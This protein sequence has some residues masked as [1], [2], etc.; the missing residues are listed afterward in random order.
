MESNRVRTRSNSTD[1]NGAEC[2]DILYSALP[3]FLF[4]VLGCVC[5]V[6]FVVDEVEHWEGLEFE[7]RPSGVA[8][9]S[10]LNPF[11]LIRLAVQRQTFLSSSPK[12]SQVH[13]S[14]TFVLRPPPESETRPLV[15]E[16]KSANKT[17]NS[18]NTQWNLHVCF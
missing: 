3:V 4:F 13:S 7:L 6:I 8:V 15:R 9:C 17:E 12:F 18:G 16:Q 11:G 1:G 5:T 10:L 14:F 2:K